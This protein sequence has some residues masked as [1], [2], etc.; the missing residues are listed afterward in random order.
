MCNVTSKFPLCQ[1]KHNK[2]VWGVW[3]QAPHIHIL[4]AVVDTQSCLVL[5]SACWEQQAQEA[6]A[7]SCHIQLG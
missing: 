5:V 3:S 7:A 1:T 2:D 6:A 4:G